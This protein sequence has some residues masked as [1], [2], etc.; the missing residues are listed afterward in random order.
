MK[1]IILLSILFVSALSCA[2]DKQPLLGDTEHQKEQ[3][4]EFKDALKSPLTEKDRKTFRAL[5]FFKFDSTYVVTAN[6][7]STPN[8]TP[9][10]MATTTDRKPMYVKYGELSFV[11]NG[12]DCKLNIYQN[13]ELVKRE[14]YEDHLFL[15][16]IDQTNG[17]ESY[18]GGRYLDTS[19][20]KGNTMVLNF[21]EA[22][23]PYC[24]YSPRYSCPI[25]PL[26]N[27]LDVRVEAGVKAYGKH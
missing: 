26:E 1:K 13:L 12:K 17:E 9:F 24:A 7:K 2:Q 23:N 16:F 22:Y 14:G 8:Q 11:L 6:F 19:T 25:V 18:G 5:D 20:P 10:E 15:P 27:S 4:A 3:N 21:N